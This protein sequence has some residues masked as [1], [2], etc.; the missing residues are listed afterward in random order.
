MCFHFFVCVSGDGID[1][2]AAVSKVWKRDDVCLGFDGS[3]ILWPG[4]GRRG[5]LQN[6]YLRRSEGVKETL[7]N[8]VGT[9]MPEECDIFDA[10]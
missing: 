5:R 9:S 4:R 6:I 1:D 7:E 2:V 3:R 8:R 10:L